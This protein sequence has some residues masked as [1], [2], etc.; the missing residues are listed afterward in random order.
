MGGRAHDTGGAAA[1]VQAAAPAQAGFCSESDQ[2]R[3][4]SGLALCLSSKRGTD[5]AKF[6]SV[7]YCGSCLSR[8]ERRMYCRLAYRTPTAPTRAA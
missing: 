6:A 8:N 3:A 2:R 1:T 7:C 5:E 4:P